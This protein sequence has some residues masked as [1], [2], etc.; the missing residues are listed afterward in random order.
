LRLLEAR[1]IQMDELHLVSGWVLMKLA[2]LDRPRRG[3]DERGNL[4]DVSVSDDL[5]ALDK[6]VNCISHYWLII[7]LYVTAFYQS[8]FLLV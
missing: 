8:H 7:L 2:V 3:A 4:Q 5:E 6:S 1:G